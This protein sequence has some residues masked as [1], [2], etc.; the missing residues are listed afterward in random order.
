[1]PLGPTLDTLLAVSPEA[2]DEYLRRYEKAK[3]YDAEAVYEGWPEARDRLNSDG[4]FAV[5]DDLVAVASAGM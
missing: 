5:L 1:M 2:Y 4:A 3:V